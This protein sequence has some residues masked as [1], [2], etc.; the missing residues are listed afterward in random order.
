MKVALLILGFCGIVVATFAASSTWG[1]RNE[2]DSVII[3]QRLLYPAIANK[4]QTVYFDL[5]A[6]NQSNSKIISAIYVLDQFQNS[7]GPTNTLVWGGPGWTYAS[8]QLRTST[9]IGLNVTA[10]VYG[11]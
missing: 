8:I 9:S 2:T 3:Q 10:V 4:A 7:T 6:S 1:V 11:K 5:P